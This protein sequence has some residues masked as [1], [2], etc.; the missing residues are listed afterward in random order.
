M[1]KES[2]VHIYNRILLGHKE[3]GNWVIYNDADELRVCQTVK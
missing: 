2:V 1:D 3:E